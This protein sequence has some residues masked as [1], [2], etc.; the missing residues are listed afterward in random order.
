MSNVNVTNHDGSPFPSSNQIGGED[1]LDPTVS[2]DFRELSRVPAGNRAG[3]NLRR[4]KCHCSYY[5][6]K[7]AQLS[8]GVSRWFWLPIRTTEMSDHFPGCKYFATAHHT[9]V[10][11]AEFVLRLTAT[12]NYHVKA[13]W[14]YSR[15]SSCSTISPVLSYRPVVAWDSPGFE[16]FRPIWGGLYGEKNKK[17]C[18]LLLSQALD[19]VRNAF[20]EKVA[21]PF[22]INEH[23]WSI[24]SVS[25]YIWFSDMFISH[26]G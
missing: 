8:S 17:E 9:R 14:L 16:P 15:K 3:K 25:P 23:G 21:S 13:S 6:R 26:T 18:K 5:M 20:D 24:P 2:Y 7:Q 19:K 11:E 22:D 4:P 10:T 1:A 12:W